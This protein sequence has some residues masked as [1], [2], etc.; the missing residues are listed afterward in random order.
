M[1]R[2]M[3]DFS[4]RPAT[5][6][7]YDFLYDLNR[8]ALGE[9]VAQISGWDE[10]WEQQNFRERFDPDRRQ[11]IRIDGEDIGAFGFYADGDHVLLDYVAILPA[12]QRRGIGSRL[13]G[14]VVEES[15]K[16]GKPVRVQV[17][18]TNP[19]TELYKRL[20]FVT[21]DETERHFIMKWSPDTPGERN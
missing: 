13:I 14:S 6:D 10:E 7:D 11:V 19:A 18:K 4:L 5:P 20:G 21:T 2:L 16:L 12:Y 17:L 1:E 8:L 9:Y 15:K 3:A